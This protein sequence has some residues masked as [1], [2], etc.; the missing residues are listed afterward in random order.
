MQVGFFSMDSAALP[1]KPRHSSPT[2]IPYVRVLV[3]NK[4]AARA[5]QGLSVYYQKPRHLASFPSLNSPIG[6]KPRHKCRK[7]KKHKNRTPHLY[8]QKA[9]TESAQHKCHRSKKHKSPAPHLY[10]AKAFSTN[11]AKGRT[12]KAAP[13][14]PH[15]SLNRLAASAKAA[16]VLASSISPF[17]IFSHT[18]A[19]G[20]LMTSRNSSA[21]RC[22]EAASR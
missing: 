9:S 2:R 16:S 21:S 7:R 1:K 6:R 17:A 4:K 13:L 5:Q 15:I 20:I 8:Q 12:E 18:S 14:I 3:Q 11:A 19:S 10:L 22:C